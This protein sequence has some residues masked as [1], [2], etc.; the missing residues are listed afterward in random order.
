MKLDEEELEEELEQE[1]PGSDGGHTLEEAATDDKLPVEAMGE[2]RELA[3]AADEWA[4]VASGLASLGR[5]CVPREGAEF[6]VFLGDVEVR[7]SLGP[8]LQE[9]ASQLVLVGM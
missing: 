4:W 7:I 8:T 1:E 9:K 6:Q 2:E 3:S 5:A